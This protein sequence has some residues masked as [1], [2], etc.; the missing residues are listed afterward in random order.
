MRRAIAS[1]ILVL[2]AAVAPVSAQPADPVRLT[3]HFGKDVQYHVNCQVEISGT[4]AVPP[5]GKET[6]SKALKVVGSSSIKYDERILQLAVDR[7]VERTVRYYRQLEFERKVGEEQQYSKLRPEAQRLVILRH[8]QYEVPFCP[9]GPLTIGEME[10][11]R[12][13]VFTPALQG[14]FPL[15]AVRVGE[16]WAADNIAIQELTDLEKIDKANLVCT[17]EKVVTLLGRRIGHVNFEGKVQG[18]GDDG[19]AL[20]ELRGSYYVDL[21]ANF[22]SYVYV[23]GTHHLLDKNGNA[24]GKIEGSFVMT[25]SPQPLTNEVSD[26]ALRG[27]TLEPNAE[28]SLLLFEHPD[29]GVRFVYPR[30]WRVAGVNDKQ[31]GIDEKRGSGVLLTLS[32]ADKTPTGAQFRQETMQYLTKQQVRLFREDA[33][34]SLPGGLE[35]FAFEAQVGK[36]R[37]NLQYYVTRQGAQGATL[38][39]RLL[40]AD[41]A[42]V[43]ADVERMV[44]SLQ[45]RPVK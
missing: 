20:H 12:T 13:D 3:E 1:L 19:I 10:L 14:L 41:L 26:Q 21:D 17:F 42:N 43:Q 22:L 36:D 33:L 29:V 2:V 38:M 11:V 15:K 28:N 7:K 6:A 45:L 27:L 31:I 40:P 8:N 24:T 9:H 25:R 16:Q 23:K 37:V 5:Q 30:N 18:V 44:R 32:S 35:T 39:A 4:L 34:R